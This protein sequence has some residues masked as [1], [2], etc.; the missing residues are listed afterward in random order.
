MSALALPRN[1]I[2]K[3]KARVK[4]DKNVA[5]DKMESLL[6]MAIK[7]LRVGKVFRSKAL[8]NGIVVELVTNCAHQYDFWAQNWWNAPSEVLPHGIVYSAVG[9]EGMEPSASYCPEQNTAIFF[10]TEYYTQLSYD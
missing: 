5:I 6:E 8:L 10:N 3:E 7:K 9:V 4:S 1:Y 2:T